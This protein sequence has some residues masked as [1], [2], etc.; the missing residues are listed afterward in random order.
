MMYPVNE[1]DIAIIGGGHVGGTLAAL[2]A[3]SGSGWRV[4]LLEAGSLQ[5]QARQTATDRR[6][7]RSTALARGTV[8]IFRELGL[9]PRLEASATAIRK[10]HVSDR[11]HLPGT[12]IHPPANP[13]DSL[14]FVV[15]NHWLGRVLSGHLLQQP[16]LDILENTRVESATPDSRG[17]LLQLAGEQHSG[18]LHAALTVIADGGNSPLR[19]SLG[20]DV[21]QQDYQQTAV[22]TNVTFSHPHRGTAWERFTDEGPMALLP[23]DGAEGKRAALIWTLPTA[24]APELLQ[25]A[26]GDFLQALQA[27]F[28]SRAGRF[29]A[30]GERVS[31]PLQLTV[32]RE[33][34][35]RGLVLA[36]NA[37]HFLHPVAG[38]GLN[39]AVRDCAML[40]EVLNEARAAGKSP[41]EP[42]VLQS[43]QQRQYADQLQTIAASDKLVKWFSTRHPLYVTLRHLGFFSLA[44]LPGLQREFAARAMGTAG[45]A[46]RWQD[47]ARGG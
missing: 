10:V 14:G 24:K 12:E 42:G 47:S 29:L 38:Q 1:V 28:G 11:G 27:R 44:A 31:F 15:E 6:D 3:A 26:P 32:A 5:E 36:G 18:P 9:W 30:V 43:Y 39:L 21:R 33:Q 46:P 25:M 8:E 13:A 40:V 7:A 37:A 22:I 19:Q 34:V 23:L 16:G 2:L 45:R 4:A 41:G 17:M 20:I 35:R